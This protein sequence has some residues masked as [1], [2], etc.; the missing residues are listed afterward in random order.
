M[1]CLELSM[2]TCAEIGVP[3]H[4]RRVSQ[5]I[6]L[7][8][9]S[10]TSQLPCMM[11]NWALLWS[12]GTGIG[13]PFKLI[14][15]TLNYFTF[16]PWHQC[17]S[18]LVNYFWGP[19]SKSVKQIKASYMFDWEKGIALHEMQGNRASSV[20]EGEVSWFLSNCGGNLGYNLELRQG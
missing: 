19:L 7:I 13:L 1:G 11:G 2:S 14:W 4:L 6:S 15:A 9:Q 16:L 5:W 18:R 8:A 10:K 3:I 17:S 12:Q 20:S